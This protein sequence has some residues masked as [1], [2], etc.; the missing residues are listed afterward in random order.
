MYWFVSTGI[1]TFF[2]SV[3][4][5]YCLS[6]SCSEV[7]N[8]VAISVRLLIFSTGILWTCAWYGLSTD[9]VCDANVIHRGVLHNEGVYR[10][11]RFT[12][13]IRSFQRKQN[14]WKRYSD[15]CGLHLITSDH[16]YLVKV[17]K[18]QYLWILRTFCQ[19]VL[20]TKKWRKMTKDHPY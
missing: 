19:K 16:V 2:Y 18:D 20:A 1:L 14:R 13:K 12:W 10:E 8:T 15:A 6:L 7:L 5:Q 17:S 11:C 9:S 3:L 4:L